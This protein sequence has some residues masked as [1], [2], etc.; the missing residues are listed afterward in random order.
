[1]LTTLWVFSF[2]NYQIHQWLQVKS[3]I[4]RTSKKHFL[5]WD[6][7]PS[8][9]KIEAQHLF[10]LIHIGVQLLFHKLFHQ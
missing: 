8:S 3:Q 5:N 10:D 1:M 7:P 9:L 2:S 6:Q 4:Q